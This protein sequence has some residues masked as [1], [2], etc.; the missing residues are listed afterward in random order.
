MGAFRVPL[1]KRA[2]R[3]VVHD[4]K[5]IV[6]LNVEVEDAHDMRMYQVSNGEGFVAECLDALLIQLRM[7]NLD[8]GL[9]VQID[10]RS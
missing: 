8:R 6:V 3:G 9:R 4:E 1:A 5:G 2:I 10:M 7:E